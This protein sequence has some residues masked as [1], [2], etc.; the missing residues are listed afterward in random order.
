MTK[1]TSIKIAPKGRIPP[2]TVE[3]TGCMYQGCSGIWRGIWWA[4]QGRS[5]ASLLNPK[6]EPMKVSGTDTPNQ[7]STRA[8]NV[9][10][11]IAPTDYL[12]QTIRL[13][14]K[15]T[16]NTAPGNRKADSSAFRFQS[17]PSKSL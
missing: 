12:L 14:A 2:T 13:S 6:Y 15:P 3:H 5:Y 8:I 11:G 10:N 7:R 9:V 1:N 4:L 17:L 16:M